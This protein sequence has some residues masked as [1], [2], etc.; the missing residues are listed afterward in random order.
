[1][2]AASAS[3]RPTSSLTAATLPSVSPI[4]A[5]SAPCRP[6]VSI[7]VCASAAPRSRITA[8]IVAVGEAS[9]DMIAR[10]WVDAS[11]VDPVTPASVA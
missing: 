1:M 5:A 3:S 6:C 7:R 11:A 8:A 10:S 4:S 2:A 9:A